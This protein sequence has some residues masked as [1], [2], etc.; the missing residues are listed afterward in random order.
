MRIL[1]FSLLEDRSATPEYSDVLISRLQAMPET[2]ARAR[3]AVMFALQ[4][5][6]QR[7]EWISEAFIRAALAELESME[8]M[9]CFDRPGDVPLKFANQKNPLLHILVLL[10]HF[11]IHI[12]STAVTNEINPILV[13]GFTI[14]ID[15]HPI[16][17]ETLVMNELQS[18]DLAELRNGK[19][20]KP[21]DLVEG[22]AWLQKAQKP[23]GIGNLI[24][25]GVA[26]FTKQLCEHHG[27]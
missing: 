11:N 5:E 12:K 21:E 20:Y 6:G 9:Q 8:D 13:N 10:R 26:T 1:D 24:T 7:E 22:V 2:H 16:V 15:G 3:S 19:K 4:A 25:Q 17:F 14:D 27:L 23:R 18:S